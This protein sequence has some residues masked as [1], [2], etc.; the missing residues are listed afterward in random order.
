MN[1]PPDTTIDVRHE[2]TLWNALRFPLQSAASRRDVVLGGLWLFVPV[3]GWLLNMGHRVRVTH[4]MHHYAQP[5]PAWERPRELLRHGAITFAGMVWYGWPGVSLAL[6]GAYLDNTPLLGVGVAL[7]MFAVIAIPG[8]MSHYCCRYD[9]KE[10]FDPFRAL[11]R[12]RQGGAAYWKAWS[13]VLVAMSLSFLGLLVGGVG[14]VFTSVWFWQVAAFCF[15]SVFTQRFDLS[16]PGPL[17]QDVAKPRV[18]GLADLGAGLEAADGHV[19]AGI[20]GDA[21]RDVREP[22]R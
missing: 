5:W 21:V 13:I 10:I 16:A 12:V 4:R 20:H 7:W 2:L 14:F 15:A 22:P 9:P 3:F 6:L 8:Y 19:A 11:R 18:A 1:L 17:R